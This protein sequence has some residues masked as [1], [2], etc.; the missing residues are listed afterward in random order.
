MFDRLIY[1]QL[2]EKILNI[3]ERNII[4]IENWKVGDI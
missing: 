2:Y 4:K 3:S 1:K